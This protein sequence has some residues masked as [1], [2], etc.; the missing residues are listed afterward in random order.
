LPTH[1]Q[2]KHGN[3]RGEDRSERQFEATALDSASEMR[4]VD[5]GEMPSRAERSIVSGEGAHRPLFGREVG[6]EDETRGC[7]ESIEG[8][9]AHDRF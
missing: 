6:D 3:D 1:S 4:V 2:D 5:N 9:P 7:R 8:A